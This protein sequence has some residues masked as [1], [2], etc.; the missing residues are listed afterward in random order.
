V[1]SRDFLEKKIDN[2]Q[3]LLPPAFD[4]LSKE[5]LNPLR[6]FSACLGEKICLSCDSNHE[7]IGIV[8]VCP[9]VFSVPDISSFFFE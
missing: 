4:I 5:A 7:L 3:E 9:S 2:S 1:E 8:G 6:A